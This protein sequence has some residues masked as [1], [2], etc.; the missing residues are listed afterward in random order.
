MRHRK[1]QRRTSKGGYDELKIKVLFAVVMGLL[2]ATLTP[3]PPLTGSSQ[4][5]LPTLPATQLAAASAARTEQ[6]Q[7]TAQSAAAAQGAAVL[8]RGAR[9]WHR[10]HPPRH[11]GG[12]NPSPSPSLSPSPSPSASA[13]PSPSPTPTPAP[14]AAQVNCALIVPAD[15]LSA[16]GLATPWQ[17]TEDGAGPCNEA[18]P[19]DSAFVEGAVV[20]PA[21]GQ[22]S[23]YDP[24]VVDRGSRPAVAPTR[25]TLP[26]GAVV[27]I[28][29]G[30][31]GDN[32][33]LRGPGAGACTFQV[34]DSAFGQNAFC[35]ATAF[36][37]AANR[38]I[39]SGKLAV[40]MLGT[41]KD[42][43]TCPTVRDFSVVDQ[44]QSDNTTTKY[45]VTA[46][47]QIAQ[48][49]P[50]N[51]TRLAGAQ[52]AKNGS[53]EGL[54]TRAIDGA[55]G[56]TPWMVPDLA[57]ATHQER[58]TSWPLNELMAAARQAPPAA[59]VPA[60]DPFVF[61]GNDP[62]LS[63]LNTYRAGVDMPR[64]G[65]LS[66]A[67]TR[68]YCRNMLRTGLP[69]IAADRTLTQAGASPFPADASNLFTFLAFRFNQAF[70]NGDGFLHC[71]QLLG[72]RNPIELR[73]TD[74][75]VTGAVINLNPGPAAPPPSSRDL[76]NR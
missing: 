53:D 44:D 42:G 50:E 34:D 33:T 54:L 9:R 74:G 28:W 13:K 16:A 62:S 17:L 58:V 6:A 49:T 38:A 71:E 59:L 48:D 30:Y 37:G 10:H 69:R 4:A 26:A 39:Q 18:N 23:A 15:P 76:K 21:T 64:V 1:Q 29:V 5:A 57:D 73:M 56:C 20:D 55:L 63:K 32:V 11:G 68:T 60:G 12:G 27:G 2:A 52:V 36:F 72:V 14:P 70:S 19:D 31:N 47:G 51:A 22:V 61:V 66:Q 43:K 75:V 8:L 35:N 45:L 65:S 40:P 25:P 46:Q 7:A 24:L 67:D 3:L 41:G